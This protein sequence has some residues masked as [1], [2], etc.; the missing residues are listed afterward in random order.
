MQDSSRTLCVAHRSPALSG[1]SSGDRLLLE[2]L[3]GGI[4][5]RGG[6]P[7][8]VI[9]FLLAA[10]LRGAHAPKKTN[11]SRPANGWIE[12]IHNPDVQVRRIRCGLRHYGAPRT[13]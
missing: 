4:I 13:S 7:C 3:V 8:A 1:F 5:A 2:G 11:Q 9:S 10:G 12:G 6:A